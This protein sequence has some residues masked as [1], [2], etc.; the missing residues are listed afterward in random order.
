MVTTRSGNKSVFQHIIQ[1]VFAFGADSK[2]EKALER[3][4][5]ST[6]H[7]LFA[8][9]D[10]DIDALQVEEEIK[11]DQGNVTGKHL[12]PLQK[13]VRSNVRVIQG[14][15]QARVDDGNPVTGWMPKRSIRNWQNC[16]ITLS[17]HKYQLLKFF[18][19]S[20]MRS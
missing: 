11:D 17:R 18:P 7:D 19:T 13:S 8:M 6:E 10:D 14:F 20:P 9:M 5:I 16:A 15:I 2:L 3:D 12:V 4:G 1:D